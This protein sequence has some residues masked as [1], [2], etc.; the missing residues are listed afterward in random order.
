MKFYRN[1]DNNTRDISLEFG[2]DPEHYLDLGI[3]IGSFIIALI[4]TI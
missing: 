1:I 2:S 4:N 3:L